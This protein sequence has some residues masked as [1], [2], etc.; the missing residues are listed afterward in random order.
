MHDGDRLG[1]H[2][3]HLV[4]T[5]ILQR[6]HVLPLR[7]SRAMDGEAG[8][9]ISRTGKDNVMVKAMIVEIR[10]ECCVQFHFPRGNRQV[11]RSIEES[12]AGMPESVFLGKARLM[13]V[14]FTLPGIRRHFDVAGAGRQRA[15][16]GR[17]PDRVQAAERVK[18]TVTN[19][20]MST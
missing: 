13:P 19:S 17:E 16:V 2:H 18:Q 7:R 9:D 8:F 1:I 3:Q 10:E 6:E 15:P 5:Q 14:P 4:E 20:Q 11:E 12:G